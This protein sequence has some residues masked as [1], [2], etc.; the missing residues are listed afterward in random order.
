MADEIAKIKKEGASLKVE[1][2]W[3]EMGDVIRAK[4]PNASEPELKLFFYQAQRTG[5]NQ[6]GRAH[7]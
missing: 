5:L 4:Y 7:V 1:T 2:D 6:I 3:K